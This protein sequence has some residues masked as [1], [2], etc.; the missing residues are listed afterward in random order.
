[1]YVIQF[2]NGLYYSPRWSEG[3]GLEKAATFIDW[4][5]AAYLQSH[6]GGTIV[7]FDAVPK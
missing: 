3:V 2:A 7:S 4:N 1:M 6:V 5:T